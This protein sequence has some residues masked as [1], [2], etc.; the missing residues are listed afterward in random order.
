MSETKYIAQGTIAQF[1]E[2]RKLPAGTRVYL[3]GSVPHEG[4]SFLWEW[5]SNR[6]FAVESA[7]RALILRMSGVCGIGAMPGRHTIEIV[8]VEP[9]AE[10][11]EKRAEHMAADLGG[12]GFSG[13]A[14]R[15]IDEDV[16]RRIFE[17]AVAKECADDPALS[18]ALK[19][20]ENG[21]YHYKSTRSA[22]I[23]WKMRAEI[24]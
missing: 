7:E 3:G 6:E 11:S 17:I 22:W 1:D 12:P 14:S 8:E 19:R 24:T 10:L 9:P 23:G 20:D 21:N 4:S 18:D 13:A 2:R 16:E 15:A 5:M